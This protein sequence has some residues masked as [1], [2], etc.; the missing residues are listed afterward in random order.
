M[1][2]H[3]PPA[4]L[5]TM[6]TTYLVLLK[7]HLEKFWPLNDPRYMWYVMNFHPLTTQI[8]LLKQRQ[9]PFTVLYII[10][11][12]TFS[13]DFTCKLFSK[14]ILSSQKWNP[15]KKVKGIH[16]LEKIDGSV[17]D[18]SSE[19]CV[20]KGWKFITYHINH[21]WAVFMYYFSKVMLLRDQKKRYCIFVIK[22]KLVTSKS[23]WKI[24][25]MVVY[26]LV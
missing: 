25:G 26:R 19:I 8:S 5:T 12:K 24:N 3:F 2:E 7:L 20:V 9:A 11:F 4:S 15:L 10:Y 6:L 22:A 16:D 21:A 23:I 1:H 13:V 17:F 14:S 18:H